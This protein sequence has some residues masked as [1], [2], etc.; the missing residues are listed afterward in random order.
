MRFLAIAI[1]DLQRVRESVEVSEDEILA[2]LLYPAPSLARPELDAV[3]GAKA[4]R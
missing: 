2:D 1:P 4:G 3:R